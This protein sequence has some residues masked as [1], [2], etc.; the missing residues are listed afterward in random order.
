[1]KIVDI[2]ATA[3]TVPLRRPLR[4][5]FG[6]EVSTT[7]TIVELITDEGLVGVG[8]TR[9]GD[10]VV[11]AL[12]LHRDIYI[13][14]DPTEVGRIARRFGIFRM[15]SEQLALVGAA[16][17]AGAAVEMACW[18]LLGKA[19]GK[20]CGDLWGG[21]ATE[22]VEFA[23]Y[24]FYRYESMTDVGRGDSVEDAAD[25]A[26]ELFDTHG[27][28]DIKFKNG[29]LPPEQ[30]IASVRLMRDRLGDRLRYLRIDPNAVWSVET[31][32]RVLHAVYDYGLEFCEDPTWGIEGMSLVRERTPVPL[33]TNMCC[34]A[35]EQIPL[36]VRQRAVDVILGDV[37]FWGGPTAVLQLAKICE[38]F[39]LGLGMHSDRELGISTAAVLHLASA[40]TMLSHTA[41]SHLPE[42]AD[43]IITTPFTFRDGCLDVPAGPGLGVEIDQD[44]L[45][46][47][48]E[49]HRKV[50]EGSEFADAA[51]AGFRAKFPRF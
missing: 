50:G 13:G 6:V 12:R 5:S 4:W 14:Q 22:R 16:K 47:Y 11:E 31:S 23:A 34:V 20:R 18:D 45:R 39:N 51:Q 38:T 33:A 37:H 41:D 36:A 48:A 46:F 25:H 30:E 35:F 40:E 49:H 10:E 8:E 17:L 44:K 26:Q 32:I 9:G 29:V 1:M 24:V 21:V 3:V 42:Q 43:D 15:T 2:R 27:F 7:R 19:L 28:R